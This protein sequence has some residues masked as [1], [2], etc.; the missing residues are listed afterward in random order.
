MSA[1]VCLF[2]KTNNVNYTNFFDSFG[3]HIY[4]GAN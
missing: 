4:F 2:V 3:D 1:A